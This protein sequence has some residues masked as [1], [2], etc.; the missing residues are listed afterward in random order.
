MKNDNTFR[1]ATFPGD[2]IGE[3]ITEPTLRLLE[4]AASRVGGF[5]F[6][7]RPAV[8]G[9]K[10][11]LDEGDA[12]PAKALT[13]ARE[14]D[15]ILL[16]AMGL[17]SVRYP[18]GREITP[19]VSLRFELGLYAGVRPVK[20]IPGV[21][22]ILADPRAH[23][24]DYVII[25]ESIEGLF[26][27]QAPGTRD[28]DAEARETMVI[29]RPVC[30]KLFDFAFKLAAERGGQNKVT[31]V[32]KANVFQAFAFWREI[33]AERAALMPNI[34]TDLAYVDAFAMTMVQKPWTIDVAVTE[35]IFGDILS[36]LGAALM[37][38]MGYAPSADIG[39]DHAV[40]QPCHGSAP[41]IAG[42]GL[43]NP[44]AMILSSAMM[45]DWLG[46]RHGSAEAIKAG[47]MLRQAVETAFA[48]GDLV[49]CELG[50]KAGT[51]DVFAAVEAALAATDV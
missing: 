19:Q 34:K 43:A 20:P 6:D 16:A 31:S 45:L 25:R 5:G 48:P 12:L 28:G 18:D 13:E 50:G 23:D 4:N 30:E 44:T 24:I 8:A 26:A 51:T 47:G 14:A 38:G 3:E 7:W 1:V 46:K 29:T 39:D 9:A 37:G 17:P 49:T 27:P 41:D 22:P 40:F 35:N 36:D 15:A 42:Q 10:C 21:R 33:F 2:G 11:Y 32:D